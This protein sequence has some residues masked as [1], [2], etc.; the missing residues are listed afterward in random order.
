MLLFHG[1]GYLL[2][3]HSGFYPISTK[4]CC[5]VFCFIHIHTPLAQAEF[6]FVLGMTTFSF[7]NN[8]VLSLGPETLPLVSKNSLLPQ[9]P[10][11]F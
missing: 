11:T 8:C 1:P 3:D 9:P 4:S 10:D 2:P 5:V 6:L 7:K